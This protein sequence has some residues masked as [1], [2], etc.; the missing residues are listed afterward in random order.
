[1]IK[2]GTKFCCQKIRSI[3]KYKEIFDLQKIN[4]RKSGLPQ[5][6]EKLHQANKNWFGLCHR[7]VPFRRLREE[8]IWV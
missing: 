3:T 2:P 1:M 6:P 7:R 8:G 4:S 5:L